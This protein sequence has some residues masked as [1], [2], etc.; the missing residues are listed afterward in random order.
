ME[1][2]KS[3]AYNNFIK[4]TSIELS[5]IISSYQHHIL[6][7]S[8]FHFITYFLENREGLEGL[9]ESGVGVGNPV[10]LCRRQRLGDS[11]CN[12]RL[13]ILWK[14]IFYGCFLLGKS[15]LFFWKDL[16]FS[17][18]FLVFFLLP[19]FNAEFYHFLLWF[20]ILFVSPVQ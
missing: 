7:V 2:S 12:Y 19:L 15:L 4:I 10:N 13:Y 18:N 8:I 9:Q 1:L 11:W 16:V 3:L 14:I 5:I 20:S 6:F 17:L